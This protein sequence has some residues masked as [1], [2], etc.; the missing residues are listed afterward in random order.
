MP[1]WVE[2]REKFGTILILGGGKYGTIALKRLKGRS[3][4]II[5]V[6]IDPNCQ[7]SN[8][9][10]RIF[11]GDGVP[12]R[13]SSLV[14]SNGASVLSHLIDRGEVPDFVVLTIPKNVMAALF[15]L[16][17]ESLGRG[18]V[19]DPNW[20]LNVAGG[21]PEKYIVAKDQTFGVLVASYAR[22]HVCLDGCI[23][24]EVCP[25]SGERRE[26]SMLDL[27][28]SLVKGDFVKIFESK[29]LECDVGGVEGKAILEAYREF[30]SQIKKGMR[31][32]IGTACRCHT[33]V[34]FMRI[35]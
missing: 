3:E 17:V 29:L 25:I 7:A 10:E 23:Q 18:V 13:G 2:Q 20:M 16:W 8:L 26:K 35:A 1:T 33:I 31:F 4:R 27:T 11:Y 6:D 5:V 32:A 9:V 21:F 19:F 30:R 28:R 24:P 12:S 14:L 15:I 22:D 34:N